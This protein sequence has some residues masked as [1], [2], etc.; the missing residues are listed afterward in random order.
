[1]KN[2]PSW[3]KLYRGGKWDDIFKMPPNAL[4]LWMYH[5][6]H[7]ENGQSM[8]VEEEILEDCGMNHTTLYRWSSEFTESAFRL[9][10]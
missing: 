5:Y 8:P 1:M 7:E 4:K 6:R 2:E 10:W 9:D 3:K